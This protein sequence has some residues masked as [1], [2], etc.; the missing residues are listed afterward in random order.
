M[1][2]SSGIQVSRAIA[3]VARV[4][5]IEDGTELGEQRLLARARRKQAHARAALPARKQSQARTRQHLHGQLRVLLQR[6]FGVLRGR[7]TTD[8]DVA[9]LAFRIARGYALVDSRRRGLDA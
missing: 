9:R 3:A 2:M 6:N 1:Y 4:A 7:A 5:R 8:D